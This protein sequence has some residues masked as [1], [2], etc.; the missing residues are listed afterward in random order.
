MLVAKL[1][2]NPCT[3]VSTIPVK[4]VLVLAFALLVAIFAV[5]NAQPVA[6]SFFGLALPSVPL[7]AIIIGM[8]AIGVLLGVIFSAPSV[9]GRSRQVRE[10]E[11]KLKESEEARAKLGEELAQKENLEQKDACTEKAE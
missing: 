7:A 3:G 9:L 11:A 10:L 5:Q 4:L 2:S 6:I 1:V 8:L